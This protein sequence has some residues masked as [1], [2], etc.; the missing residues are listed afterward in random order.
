MGDVVIA[1]LRAVGY[2]FLRHR[3]VLGDVVWIVVLLLVS[4]VVYV[5][6]GS[7]HNRKFPREGAPREG[8][9]SPLILRTNRSRG[10]AWMILERANLGARRSTTCGNREVRRSRYSVSLEVPDPVPK[11]WAVGVQ[12][13]R[14][15]VAKTILI[16][17]GGGIPSLL[18]PTTWPGRLASLG[19]VGVAA[20]SAGL[21]LP[22]DPPNENSDRQVGAPSPQED[23]AE[24]TWRDFQRR[25]TLVVCAVCAAIVGVLLL[26]G[27]GPWSH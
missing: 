15:G 26:I 20:A 18:L 1:L 7:L 25:R 11:E 19:V 23:L 14:A 4:G 3:S 5:V 6:V 22:R 8:R 9:S 17:G 2:P 13:L 12:S 24:E 16:G 21:L 27:Y 10:T